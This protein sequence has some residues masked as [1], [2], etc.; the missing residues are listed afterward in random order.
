MTALDFGGA[1]AASLAQIEQIVIDTGNE[2]EF[3]G[4][5]VTGL[6]LN[7]N[8]LA[9]GTATLDIDLTATGA[10]D[11]SNFTFTAGG[12]DAFDDAVDVID[13][14]GGSG[15]NVIVGSSFKD[16]I[17][18]GGGGDTV[19]GGDGS[20]SITLGA[21]TDIVRYLADTAAGVTGTIAAAQGDAVTAFTTGTDKVAFT[22]D[23]LTGA[24]T[25]TTA[26]AVEAVGNAA[27]EDL[28][29]AGLDT[30]LLFAGGAGNTATTGDLTTIADLTAAA[31][32]LANAVVGDERI[33]IFNTDDS[34]NF[35]VYKYVE[36]ANTAVDAA[37]LSL[38]GIFN[39]V[40][41][42]GDAQFT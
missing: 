29:V 40:F 23:F 17:A 28:D 38:I 8:E 1:D 15:A 41:A 35:A 34:S 26:N 21:G 37:D 10:L 2:L 12:G 36:T 5:Q 33:M 4:A 19:T 25:G 42:A 30:V 14:D 18:S 31:G 13:I 9:A 39:G 27:G 6:T 16:T 22:G 7:I 11:I 32:T 3:T 24:M 20:D